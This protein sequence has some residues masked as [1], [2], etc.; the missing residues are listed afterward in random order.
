MG[1]RFDFTV[2]ASNRIEADKY[3][4]LAV[5]EIIRIEKLISSWDINSQKFLFE[6]Y[7]SLT[8]SILSAFVKGLPKVLNLIQLPKDKS[9]FEP[10]NLDLSPITSNSA[11][12]SLYCDSKSKCKW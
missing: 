10:K 4:D 3:I 8:I 1:S 12:I 7:K 9:T 6:S 5:A 2:V 11:K